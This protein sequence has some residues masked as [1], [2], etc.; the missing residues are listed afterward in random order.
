MLLFT[1][2]GLSCFVHL[3]DCGGFPTLMATCKASRDC[4]M[5]K[6]TTHCTKSPGQGI[7]IITVWLAKEQVLFMLVV[8]VS[9]LLLLLLLLFC[10][11]QK[12]PVCPLL[13]TMYTRP[14][15]FLSV[16]NFAPGTA[17]EC[18][19]PGPLLPGGIFFS[20]GCLFPFLPCRAL[21][22]PSWA[23]VLSSPSTWFVRWIVQS[24][25]TFASLRFAAHGRDPC[26]EL[27]VSKNI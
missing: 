10:I 18:F 22:A 19:E 27:L 5:M 4:L 14:F 24:T 15:L 17:Q 6:R 25:S 16:C 12:N 21:S 2:I 23:S 9:M 3:P 11:M 13:C 26:R 7:I 1:F 8:V 20:F